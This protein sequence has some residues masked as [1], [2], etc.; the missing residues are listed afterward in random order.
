[1]P[2]TP[3][4]TEQGFRHEPAPA[5]RIGIAVGSTTRPTF[6]ELLF[7]FPK[8]LFRF[9]KLLF[10]FPACLFTFPIC[11]LSYYIYCPS[12]PICHIITPMNI[13]RH[14]T[15]FLRLAIWTVLALLSAC[16]QPKDRIRIEGEIAGVKQ[17]EFYIYCDDPTLPMIDTIRIEDGS[18]TYERPLSTP[19]VLTLLY[20]NFSQ[21][22]LVGEPGKNIRMKGNAA[23]LGEADITGSEENELLTDFRR[24]NADR[25]AGDVRMAAADFVQSHPKTLAAFAVFKKYF[26]Q[27]EQPDAAVALPL[28][29][30]LR[31]EQPRNAAIAATARRLRP[32]LLNG[33]GQTWPDFSVE[34]LDGRRLTKADFAGKPTLVVFWATWSNSSPAMLNKIKRIRNAR[35]NRLQLLSVSLDTDVDACRHRADMDSITAVTVCDGKAFKS[36]TVTT[37][38]LRY[39][40]GNL[41]VGA[42]GIIKARDVAPQ[43]LER[44]IDELMK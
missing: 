25:P 4:R 33:R 6:P 18:F 14:T 32:Q 9:P 31:R 26:A 5:G 23:K 17:A 44:R 36:P 37:F 8:L 35:G 19:V 21:T 11:C 40:P 38:G 30:L 22:Y 3:N 10:R 28:L 29:D 34:T 42:D 16:S 27:A 1:M 41:L 39:V 13:S 43:D 24:E 7:R 2:E 15:L 12:F 20:P